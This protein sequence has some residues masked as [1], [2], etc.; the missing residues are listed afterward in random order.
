MV[1]HRVAELG[2]DDVGGCDELGG[3]GLARLR[4]G[5]RGAEQVA[6]VDDL[7][8]A[9]AQRVGEA[10]VLDLCLVEVGGVLQQHLVQVERM[11]LVQLLPG[12]GEH[13]PLE[14]ADF[15]VHVDVRHKTPLA[16]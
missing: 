2:G 8:A 14:L 4:L 15:R 10:V 3:E 11:D 1:G 6:L 5:H 16:V 7:G 13:D 12:S 9:G